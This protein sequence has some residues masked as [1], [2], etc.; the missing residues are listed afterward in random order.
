M[1]STPAP[2]SFG[3]NSHGEFLLNGK[4]ISATDSNTLAAAPEMLSEIKE[5]YEWCDVLRTIKLPGE[6]REIIDEMRI[7]LKA[8]HAKATGG[9]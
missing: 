1:K 6:A 2:W 4:P 5:A 8:M 7:R 3:L 9:Q